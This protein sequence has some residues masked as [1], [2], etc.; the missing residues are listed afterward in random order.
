MERVERRPVEVRESLMAGL[1]VSEG[2]LRAAER[3]EERREEVPESR[4]RADQPSQASLN[5]PSAARLRLEENSRLGSSLGL[6]PV[7]RN[8]VSPM[9]GRASQR[10]SPSLL[11]ASSSPPVV[12]RR[13]DIA[14]ANPFSEKSNPFGSP[15]SDESLGEDNPFA[16]NSQR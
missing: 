4:L 7:T 6:S 13:E 15:N 1:E 14:P 10:A 11:Q 3:R 12:P 9:V 8:S 5:I 2:R 16:E